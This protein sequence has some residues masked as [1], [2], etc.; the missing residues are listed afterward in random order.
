M[1]MHGAKAESVC[2]RARE[3]ERARGRHRER[4]REKVAEGEGGGE[5]ETETESLQREVQRA[6]SGNAI[7][8]R[9]VSGN[10]AHT[11]TGVL[12]S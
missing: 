9:E 11:H 1:L 4:E 6:S 3:G 5:G 7:L 10:P 12:R 2:E 8:K